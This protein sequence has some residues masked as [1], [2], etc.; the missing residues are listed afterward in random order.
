[1][2]KGVQQHSYLLYV[3]LAFAFVCGIVGAVLLVQRQA[4][5]GAAQ[6]LAGSFSYTEDFTTETYKDASG[7]TLDWSA[8]AGEV[9]LFA[10]AGALYKSD[11]LTLGSDNIT[12]AYTDSDLIA[13]FS[14]H[15]ALALDSQARPHIVWH[16]TTTQDIQYMYWNGSAWTGFAGPNFDI[17]SNTAFETCGPSLALDSQ[18]RPHVAWMQMSG[19]SCGSSVDPIEIHYRTWNGSAWTGQLGSDDNVSNTPLIDSQRPMIAVG[20]DDLPVIAWT[21]NAEGPGETRLARF[22]GSAWAGYLGSSPDVLGTEGQ[23]RLVLDDVGFPVVIWTDLLGVE[24]TRWNG[25][26]F[27]QTDGSTPGV[28]LVTVVQCPATGCD[29]V[30]DSDNQPNLLGV[31]PG[32]VIGQDV[33][34][35]RWDQATEQWVHAD[36]ATLTP[37]SENLTNS[38]EFAPLHEYLALAIDSLD[39]PMVI[40]RDDQSVPIQNYLTRWSGTAWSTLDLSAPGRTLFTHS[41][42][43]NVYGSDIAFDSNDSVAVIWNELDGSEFDIFYTRWVEPCSPSGVAQSLSVGTT[44]EPILSATITVD[45][46]LLGGS[47]TYQLSNNGGVSY[48]TVTPGTPHSFT[49]VG[50]D[51]R[52]RAVATRGQTLAS[53]PLIDSLS[54]NFSTNPIVRI[55]GT[56]PVEQSLAIS[57]VRFPNADS[58]SSGALTRSDVLIDALT[59]APL[60]SRTSATH[61][62]NPSDVLDSRVLAEFQRAL[63]NGATVYIGGREQAISLQIEQ[64]LTAAGFT[65]VR[66]GGDDRLQ[67]ASYI[68]DEVV[69]L[70]PQP[71]TKVFMA[72]HAE[73][74]D[75]LALGSIVGNIVDGQADPVLL[76]RRGQKTLDASTSAFFAAHPTVTTVELV[77]GP[78]ALHADLEEVLANGRPQLSSISR[79]H[80]ANRFATNAALAQA[81][82]GAPQMIVIANGE[83][84]GLPGASVANVQAQSISGASFFDALLAGPYAAEHQAALL[85]TRAAQLPDEIQSYL[86]ANAATI[87]SAVIIGSE[88]LVSAT[89]EQQV[90]SLLTN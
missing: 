50:T 16:N 36:R 17:V 77:G 58:A 25:S 73:F 35:T 44:S 23:V 24:L 53:C 85:L 60:V 32:G 38:G 30:L 18:D 4:D 88:E 78:M 90:T 57:L 48:E 41:G 12:A 21:E 26:Q 65:V 63:P 10:D 11:S 37:G 28:E 52:W 80:G 22:T 51:L 72:E 69:R 7:T 55:P 74:A 64:D 34:F 20:P 87:T 46:E 8:A 13:S 1:M 45:H 68:A 31:G 86:A 5:R 43:D 15:R 33:Y 9:A 84:A 3:V 70:N 47:I 19:A 81:H 83:Q 27:V 67:T 89:V 62:L 61:L 14:T 49:T 79:T 71:T 6:G 29:I 2:T 66:L 82:I 40:Y 39:R 75:A 59:I 54:I 76:N 56:T 42:S